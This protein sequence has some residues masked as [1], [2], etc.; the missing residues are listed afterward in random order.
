MTQHQCWRHCVDAGDAGVD[1][2]TLMLN[3][4]RTSSVGKLIRDIELTHSMLLM[5]WIDA[6]NTNE[7]VEVK[8]T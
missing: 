6:E 1:D 4:P 7:V 3:A 8:K 2:G 5:C